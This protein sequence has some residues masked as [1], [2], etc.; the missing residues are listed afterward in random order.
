MEESYTG[1]KPGTY[2]CA[3]ALETHRKPDFNMWCINF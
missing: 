1:E 3:L 2:K